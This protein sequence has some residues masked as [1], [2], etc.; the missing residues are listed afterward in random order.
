MTAM[1]LTAGMMVGTGIF[2]TFGEATAKAQNGILIAM[3]IGML[4][5]LMTGI[6]AAQVG[7]NYPVEGGAFAWMRIFGHPGVAFT[8]GISYLLKGIFG[9]GLIALG[10]GT[11]TAYVFPGLPPAL[12][13]SIAIVIVAVINFF[14]IQP[15]SK[16]IIGIF[17]V[18]LLL[19]GVY[20]AYNI[21]RIQVENLTPTGV[22][23]TGLFTGAATFFWSWDG[24]QRTAIMA[25]EMKDPRK[26][27]PFAIVGGIL[28]AA[29]VYLVVAG[30]T[31]GSVGAKT[32]SGS[33]TALFLGAK[34]CL[35]AVAA[36]SFILSFSDIT[37]DIMSTSKVGH[38]MGQEHELPHWF[39]TVHKKLKSPQY[40]IVL[41]SVFALALV[42][43]VPIK[44]IIPM[45]NTCTLLWYIVT[46]FC[47]LKLNKERRFITPIISIVGIVA[48]VGFLFAL[49]VWSIAGAIG[50]LALC[51]G[52]RGLCIRIVQKSVADTC[53][54]WSVSGLELAQGDIISVTAQY[55]GEAVSS[56][57]TTV[58]A[59]APVQTKPP[60]IS[61][62]VTDADTT[63]SGKAP[64]GS[65]I[66]FRVNGVA[67]QSV[68]ANGGNWTVSG[69]TLKQGDSITVTAQSAGE[70]V[71]TEVTENITPAPFK[72]ADIT[73]SHA[74][75]A[76]STTVSGT[77]PSGASVVLS[78]NKKS[79]PEVI[80]TDGKW[81]VSGLSLSKGDSI[82]VTA[83]YG[84]E[85]SNTAAVTTVAPAPV[86][87]AE[88][89]VSGIITATDTTVS[90]K[91]PS[92]SSVVL[93]VNN[94]IKSVIT[95]T[96]GKM[97][98]AAVTT[99][100]APAPVQTA[101]PGISGIIKAGDKT[102]S[103]TAPSNASIVLSINGAA[104]PAVEATGGNWMVSGLTLNQ[105]DSISVT[106][107]SASESLSSPAITQVQ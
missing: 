78:V 100:V 50:V 37:G 94:K 103:G 4:V 101:P 12:M 73:I 7:V 41:L 64:K 86:Q 105:G 66:I 27:I 97:I 48:C 69:L 75:T 57:V 60:V 44:Q 85:Q 43:F 72:T 79:E 5:A 54:N 80:A 98:S 91:A 93:K 20:V 26:T 87:T 1:L 38:A 104:K 65:N 33:D 81:T 102:I 21:P 47:A 96:D 23:F 45:V 14:G 2:T 46:N 70:S 29:V 53:G 55:A 19:F 67:Q 35:W 11:Y 13:G 36:S 10:F 3:V 25:S 39:G 84:D 59:A 95:A 31:L 107:Q 56:P 58:V 106:A 15:S 90:G 6:S 16:F 61:M 83:K 92:G 30:V 22:S 89:S 32:I 49:P 24:F 34:G 76:A 63:V 68:T 17:F 77:A 88:A 51:I 28:T 18:N 42:N 8:A 40:M 52:I 9:L 74:V 82:S 62:P 71:S 99:E